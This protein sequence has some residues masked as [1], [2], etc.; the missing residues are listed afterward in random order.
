MV[1]VYRVAVSK[2]NIVVAGG[3]FGAR[4]KRHWTAVKIECEWVGN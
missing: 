2:D 4:A 1:A 3:R